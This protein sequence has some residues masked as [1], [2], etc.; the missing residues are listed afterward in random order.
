MFQIKWPHEINSTDPLTKTNYITE[1]CKKA[2]LICHPL[3][4]L[5]INCQK[6]LLLLQAKRI[7]KKRKI[8][9]KHW[10]LQF[11]WRWNHKTLKGP[12]PDKLLHN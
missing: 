1:K 11:H 4:I 7:R 8:R 12:K 10:L 9:K 5:L 6:K 2:N 3:A